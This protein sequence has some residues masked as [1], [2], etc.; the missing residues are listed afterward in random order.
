[1]FLHKLT[2]F[3]LQEEDTGAGGGGGG[4]G[5]EDKDKKPDTG[6]QEIALLKQAVGLLAQ[7][8]KD[9]NDK[10]VEL[11]GKLTEYLAP[12]KEED[13]PIISS[14]PSKLFEGVDLTQL[15]NAGLANLV[16]QKATDIATKIT[17][18]K[19]KEVGSTFDGKLGELANTVHSKNAKEAMQ[20]VAKDNPDFMEW[21]PEMRKVIG[22]HP[23]VS[24]QQAYVL[25]R[26]ENPH[27]VAEMTKKYAKAPEVK[28]FSFAP[29]G[30]RSDGGGKMSQQQAAEKAFDEVFGSAPQLLNSDTKLF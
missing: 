30:T 3:G 15:D 27:K 19:M 1:M 14:D 22:E 18:Q 23:S 12:K 26:A 25:A 2:G 28:Y 7:G 5:M 13:D 29:S 9:S 20:A 16:V 17:E 24:I 10:L 21:G 11:T 6:A 8:Q 4:G